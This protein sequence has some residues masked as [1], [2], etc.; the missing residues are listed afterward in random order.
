MCLPFNCHFSCGHVLFS[1]TSAFNGPDERMLASG[2]IVWAVQ[3]SHARSVSRSANGSK[4]ARIGRLSKMCAPI[5]V[6]FHATMDDTQG[7]SKLQVYFFEDTHKATG[8]VES[9][10]DR[11]LGYK[12]YKGHL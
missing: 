4:R 1:D 7:D 5:G 12:M 2:S 8:L 9:L 6:T 11:Q 3:K 10:V